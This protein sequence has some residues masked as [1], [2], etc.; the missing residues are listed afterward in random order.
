MPGKIVS[1]IEQDFFNYS[2]QQQ[3]NIDLNYSSRSPLRYP[4]G[5][6]RAIEFITRFFPK[7]LDVLLSPFFG[8]GS[9]E[10]SVASQGTMVYGYD[11]FSPLVEFWQCLTTQ[12][13]QLADEVE[14]YYPLPKEKFYELQHTQTK[15]KTKLERAAVY[16]VLNRSSFSG[17]TFSGGMSPDHPR[18]TLSSIERLRNHSNPNI[19]IAKADFKTSL[20]KHPFAFAYL[21]PPYLI[22]S[23]LYGKKGNAHKDFDHEGLADVLKTREHWILSYNDCDEI[24]NL[25]EGFHILTPNWKYGMSNDK[26]SKEVLIFSKNYKLKGYPVY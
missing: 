7:N 9:I 6:T 2:S 26:M 18:F 8:G 20:E 23:S 21:D 10:L 3:K 15:F 16:Y 14:K 19:K 1:N 17:A 25:Y 22:K 12:P 13:N 4:G 24:R 11:I 5:K